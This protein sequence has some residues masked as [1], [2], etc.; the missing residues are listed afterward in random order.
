MTAEKKSSR[1]P[2]GAASK[3][4]ESKANEPIV[5]AGPVAVHVDSGEVAVVVAPP[6]RAGIDRRLFR[7]SKRIQNIPRQDLRAWDHDHVRT[8]AV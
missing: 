4:T 3:A 8:K 2:K 5:E 1:K 7:L 6:A